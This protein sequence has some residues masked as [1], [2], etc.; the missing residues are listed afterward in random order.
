MTQPRLT[1]ED[2]LKRAADR[3]ERQLAAWLR[4]CDELGYT[5]DGRTTV[6]ERTSCGSCWEAA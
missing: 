4:R 5:R 3:F 6:T 1:P 2:A